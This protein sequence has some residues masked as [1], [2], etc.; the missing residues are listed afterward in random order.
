MTE[1]LR[2]L[3]LE[4]IVE[5]LEHEEYSNRMLQGT[6]EKYQYLEKQKRSFLS[7]LTL[8]TIERKMELDAYINLYSK[9]PVR[10]MKPVIRN[11]LRLSVYQMI[12]MDGIPISAVC[13]EAVKLATL[14]GF[15]QLKG[16]VNGVLRNTA[17]GIE[18]EGAPALLE[19]AVVGKSKA[20]A[21]S[22]RYSVPQWMVEDWMEAYGEAKT[23]EMLADFLAE[24]D[25]VI[26]TNTAKITPEQLK[27]RLESE[28]VTV[29]EIP[30]LS[31]AFAISGYDY[32]KALPSFTEGL[33]YVQDVTSML[34]SH[35]LEIQ[36]GQQV[37]DV[38]AAP[39]GKSLHAATFVGESGHV[40][41]RDVSADKVALI[42]ENI[43]RSEAT[44]V[45]AKVWDATVLD[46]ACVGKMDRVI[47]DLPCSGLGVLSG[48]PEIKYRMSREDEESL[49]ALQQQM[50]D[51]V[52]QYVKVGGRMA[53]STCTI[54][55][56][57]NENNTALFL[58]HHPEFALLSEEQLLPQ[59]GLTDGFY[60]AILE[61][62]GM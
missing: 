39:G 11:I 42:E 54:D 26:R 27:A 61:R 45:T 23:E 56:L 7:R 29:K 44:N 18:S 49:A 9:T 37:L 62:K 38:C 55:R 41:A 40:E 25:T 48:K 51:V 24:K 43:R 5:V 34:V 1:N 36:Q 16:F 6:L 17:R 28:G 4:I 59:A 10:K 53:F 8:G 2:Q 32:L 14:R 58:Q 22:I 33:F 60:I 12:Y 50:L 20:E 19:Q 31:Y 47:A 15:R 46:E 57:E 35:R 3:A 30:E 13:N 21:A 52:C